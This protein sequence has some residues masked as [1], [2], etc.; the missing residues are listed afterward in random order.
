M[1][2]VVLTLIGITLMV[3][4]HAQIKGV[5]KAEVGRHD[6]SQEEGPHSH[7]D[8][9]LP[10]VNVYWLGTTQGTTTDS[11][12]KFKIDE[13]KTYPAQLVIRF[14]GFKT[15]TIELTSKKNIE[16][17]LQQAIEMDEVV[18]AERKQTTTLDL[19]SSI[20]IEELDE[21]ELSRAACCNISEAFETNASID[22]VT[23]DGVTGAKKI[24]ML[25]LDGV[26]TS[27]QAENIPYV[28]G[29]ANL[30]GLAHVPGT[31]VESIQISKGTG[32]VV[33]GYEPMTGQINL[34]LL[35]P[36]DL[37]EKLFINLY[38]NMMGRLEANVH[39]G[40]KLSEKWSTALLVHAN[41][42]RQ[43][44]DNNKDGFLD[45][46]LR[47]QMNVLNRW[48]YFGKYYRAQFGFQVVAEDRQGGQV[49]FDRNTDYNTTN[50][51]GTGASANHYQAF[52]K[53]GILF[54]GH[55]HRS[56]ALLARGAM[57]NQDYYAGLHQYN[58]EENYLY[59]NLIF[60]DI[61][62]S[63]DHKY[64]VGVSYVYD[65]YKENFN[66]QDFL[67]EE[68]VPGVFGEYT[69]SGEKF[70][71]VIGAR[72]DFHNLFGNQF[73]PK[74]NL[75]YNFSQRGVFR[76][77]GGR[78]WRVPNLFAENASTFVSQRIITIQNSV[79]PEIALTT[80]SSITQK[81]QVFGKD[82][83]LHGDYYYTYFENQLVI[84]RELP[85]QLLFYN[86]T[87]NSHSHAAQAEVGYDL[88]KELGVKLAAKYLDVRS[89]YSTGEQSVPL[90]PNWR[91]MLS[92]GYKTLNG[93][94][95]A[96]LTT[97][98]VGISRLPSTLGN[99]PENLREDES[100]PYALINVQLTRRLKWVEV[101]VGS[102]N[103]ANYQQPN[104][105]ISADK[106][107]DSE[108]DAS[109]IWA[110]VMGRNVYAGLRFRFW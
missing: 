93:K 11:Q 32:S 62:K 14:V 43:K 71:A 85:G 100:D 19:M 15:D 105:I 25:G 31:W 61:I 103:L 68:Q 65:D 20:N 73:S 76:I 2:N 51:Y 79:K 13:P 41:A 55:P 72:G 18:V 48:K 84:D 86:L 107:F 42:I 6:H 40:D 28:R 39:L 57:Y 34:E 16:V 59:G 3:F 21:G 102:E 47:D 87:G 95:Q 98:F 80:G 108:F 56:M 49:D 92:V 37:E 26:Y 75:K 97:Q 22:V 70:G 4:A 82:M 17:I 67:R 83:T 8:S 7:E 53:N 33:N 99:S 74:V 64:V 88:F 24:Q 9:G 45:L 69:F 54:K 52:F 23:S 106:P 110:P 96:D 44:N 29:L 63:T 78:G 101:Y 1:K 10:G 89:T 58:G 66:G 109:M 90:V 104:A 38:G 46:P 36:D 77:S 35:K 60:T 27:I 94:W 81:I 91:G 30:D 5:V 50:K 12:G